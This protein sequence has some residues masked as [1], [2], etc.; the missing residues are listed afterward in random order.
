MWRRSGRAGAARRRRTWCAAAILLGTG[1]VAAT[2]TEGSLRDALRTGAYLRRWRWPSGWRCFRRAGLAAAARLSA[3]FLRRAGARL[4]GSR[5][6]RHRQPLPAR[7]PGASG[8]G[9]AGRRRDVHAHGVPGAERAG[10]RRSA[11]AR[12]RA[13]PTCFCWIFPARSGRRVTDLHPAAAGVTGGARC[14]RRGGRAHHRHRRRAHRQPAAA[15]FRPPLPAHPL[16]DGDGR[17]AG[18]NRDPE[19]RVVAARR[20]RSASLRHRGSRPHPAPASRAR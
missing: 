19:R 15:R 20:P 14:G 18:R 13:C 4:P 6:P 12:R 3:A 17:Q 5:A 9:G 16:G 1:V 10:A 7:Q 11:A 2:L 8:G